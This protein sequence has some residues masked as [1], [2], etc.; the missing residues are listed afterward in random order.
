MLRTLAA[1]IL[2]VLCL[3]ASPAQSAE[4][5]DPFRFG[6]GP[7]F[8]SE[9]IKSVDYTR[10][11]K[12]AHRHVSRKPHADK[13]ARPVK[14]TDSVPAFSR[15]TRYVARTLGCAVN[16]GLALAE[17]GLRG[18]GSALAKSY[19]AWGRPSAIPVPGAIAIWNRGRDRQ[20][21]HAAIVATI[22]G[23]VVYYWNPSSRRG[24]S[25]VAIRRQP[26]A[27]RVPA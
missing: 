5:S 13:L 1:S 23:R 4:P 24:W 3:L 18:T 17:R 19:L 14:T 8:L 26:I 10:A 11:K 22:V 27:Y 9:R 15:P 21:G 20:S 7:H 12:R 16:V 25:F 6:P 2:L